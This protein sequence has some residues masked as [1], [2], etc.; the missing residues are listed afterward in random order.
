M[1][2]NTRACGEIQANQQSDK[3]DL[4]TSPE[5]KEGRHTENTNTTATFLIPLPSVILLLTGS[6]I[7]RFLGE[8][9]AVP[10]IASCDLRYETILAGTAHPG[11]VET[12]CTG[13]SS[14]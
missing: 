11:H 7:P 12:S 13:D 5:R 10:T 3:L 9:R 4:F 14:L 1:G 8:P 2:Q 6:I